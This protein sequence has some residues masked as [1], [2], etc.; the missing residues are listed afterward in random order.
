VGAAFSAEA[1]ATSNLSMLKMDDITREFVEGCKKVLSRYVG[2]MGRVF[3]KEEV[4]RLAENGTFSQSQLP[5]LLQKLEKMIESEAD[6]A[7]FRAD[8]TNF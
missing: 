3:V 8:L 2:P 1:L 4:L 7:Q 5:V 6:R